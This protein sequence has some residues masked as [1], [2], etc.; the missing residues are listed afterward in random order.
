MVKLGKS[1][2]I[3]PH[4]DDINEALNDDDAAKIIAVPESHHLSTMIGKGEDGN[5]LMLVARTNSNEFTTRLC[6]YSYP[7]AMVVARGIIEAAGLAWPDGESEMAE[8]QAK[9]PDPRES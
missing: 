5:L 8:W 4:R 9:H 7:E 3:N 1:Q 2:R 6:V